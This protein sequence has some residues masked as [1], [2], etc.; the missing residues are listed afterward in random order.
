MIHATRRRLHVGDDEAGF[1]LAEVLIAMIIIAVGLLGLMAVQVRSLSTIALAKERQTATGLANRA[2]EQLRAVPYTVLQGGLKCSELAGDPNLS[3]T[4][5]A[6]ACTATFSPS[7]DSSIAGESV[8]TTTGAQVAPLSPHQP[9]DVTINAG[10]Y[11]V[12]TYVTRV[13]SNPAVDA[14]YWITAISTWTSSNSHQVRKSLAVRSQVYSPS[15]CLSPT[16]HPFSGPCQAFLYSNAGAIAGSIVVDANRG[17]GSP[18]VDGM[19]ATN[20]SVTLAGLS[21]RTQY[22]QSLSTQSDFLTSLA[23]LVDG[24]TTQSGAVGGSS[25]ADTDPGT[26]NVTTPAS[27]TTGSQSATTLTSN[28]G[29]SRL[30]VTA[31]PS[32]SGSAFSTI[33]ASASPICADDNAVTISGGQNC[34]SST[35]TP[36]GTSALVLTLNSLGAR[37]ITVADVGAAATASRAFGGRFPAASASPAHCTTTSGT[38]CVASGV[39]RSLGT[40]HAGGFAALGGGDRFVDSSSVDRSAA[41]GSNSLVTITGYSDSA[42]AESGIS[43]G[44]ATSGRAGTL[45]YWNG[46]G[47]TSVNLASAG[48]ATYTVP[49]VIGQYGG[50]SVVVSG[51]VTVTA[52]SRPAT[53]S[54]PCVTA[55]CGVKASSGTVV[56]SLT[57]GIF[58]GATQVGGFTVR[59]DLGSALAQT[60]YKGAPSA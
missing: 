24:A 19:T 36:G 17:T 15:G 48:S 20:G 46:T 59:L 1:S 49:Q 31:A 7:Y 9:A 33:A 34:A 3:V 5:P 39:H 44:T 56:V 53:G 23:K 54:S 18:L 40:A 22:E 38:G 55:A 25:S 43:P 21:A 50:T 26:G 51:T 10:T 35:L 52:P 45:S 29:G 60:T 37:S 47:F 2:M 41:I 57:Y 28:G 14:G 32:D 8:V 27:A 30:D 16:T 42:Y 13:N 11:R 4:N 12:R 6:G 58:S